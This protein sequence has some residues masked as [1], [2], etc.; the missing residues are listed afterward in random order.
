MI[1]PP[2]DPIPVA[3]APVELASV[4]RVGIEKE[5]ITSAVWLETDETTTMAEGRTSTPLKVDADGETGVAVKTG[6][7]AEMELVPALAADPPD[8]EVGSDGD[9][10]AVSCIT[11]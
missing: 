2:E 5:K 11:W 4:S 8:C 9:P 7:P 10:D 3:E 6:P 1:A